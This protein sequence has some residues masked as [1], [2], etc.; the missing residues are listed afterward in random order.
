MNAYVTCFNVFIIAG[1]VARS[2]NRMVSI[3]PVT[4]SEVQMYNKTVRQQLPVRRSIDGN[5]HKSR[6]YV[7][8]C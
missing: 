6:R 7:L 2:S 1:A 5:K 4:V 8:S 3:L